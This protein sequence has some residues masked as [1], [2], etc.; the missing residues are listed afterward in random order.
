VSD[1][2]PRAIDAAFRLYQLPQGVFSIALAT[3]LFPT[4]ARYA[5]RRDIDGLRRAAA[6]GTR[7]NLLLLIPAAVLSCVLAEPIVRLIYQHGEFGPSSTEQVKTAL[8]WFS[9]SL[10]LN[11][12]NLLLTRTF[13]SFQRPWVPTTLALG[14]VAVNIG[15]SAALYGPYGIGGIVAGTL[16][17]NV[18]L[19]AGQF[20]FLRRA[21]H[22]FELRRT[23][24]ATAGM[25]AA[26]ALLGAVA[27]GSWYGLD[28]A[29]GR[30]LLA[31][32]VSV[33]TACVAGIGAY[34]VG[35]W[36]LRIEEARQIWRLLAGRLRRRNATP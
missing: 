11:G 3:V 26:S 7:Q 6:N 17:A 29:L 4:L 9:F 36:A 25:L 32:T 5:T 13:F 30:S 35:V 27:Y 28:Q 21:L 24:T 1:Q 12:V 2:A 22:G 33:G 20:W 15:V 34:I 31:Q 14:S 16:A 19:T 8:F 23:A 18:A 10:P